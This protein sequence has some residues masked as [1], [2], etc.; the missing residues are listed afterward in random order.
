MNKYPL[1]VVLFLILIGCGQEQKYRI[2]Q[3]P[4]D[5]ELFEIA[6]E[7]NRIEY[8]V[9]KDGWYT[10][11]ADKYDQMLS[12]GEEVLENSRQKTGLP[13][14]TKCHERELS[15]YLIN[16]S[17]IF[18]IEQADKGRIIMMRKQDFD[19]NN[20]IVRSVCIEISCKSENS[21]NNIQHCHG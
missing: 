8:V 9:D 13:L 21:L 11:S 19:K 16:N 4:I 2:S 12:I 1:T 10:T 14:T 5:R 7:E 20:I 17:I 18:D 6:L 3:N 15:K